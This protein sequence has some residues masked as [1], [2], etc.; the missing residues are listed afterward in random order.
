MADAPGSDPASDAD[1]GSELAESLLTV[2]ELNERIAAIVD[3][4]DGLSNVACVGE[5]IDCHETSAALYFTLTGEN[6]ELQCVLWQSR[7][8][9][10]DAALED[11]AEVIVRGNVDFWTEGGT[12]S[13]KP[14][15][16]ERV[17]DGDRR[18]RI[19]RLRAELAERG[20]F[21]DEV[22]RDL[23][24]FPA[25]VGV[26]TSRDGD[27]RHDAAETIHSRYPDVDV[28]LR[29]ANVQGDGAAESLAEGIAALDR[30]GDVDVLVVC[31][32]GGSDG[33]LLAF[34][35]EL[36]A[37]AIFECETPVVAAVGHREDRTVADEVADVSAITPTAAGETVVRRKAE[38][39]ETLAER[40]RD[41]ET[42]VDRIARTAL[43][44]RATRLE[45]AA[46]RAMRADL[47][48]LA[49]TLES[50]ADRAVGRGLERSARDLERAAANA[51]R[52]ELSALA[53]RFDLA[54]GAATTGGLAALGRR[55]E[56]AYDEL[57]R[58]REHEREKAAAVEAAA[59]TTP[60]WVR[61]VIV[62]LVALVLC[63]L[64]ALALVAL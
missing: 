40:E 38:V 9:E 3:A 35:T 11:G 19:E 44:D 51:T 39:L 52:V 20:W 26:V 54:A 61:V 30:H 27:A 45:S 48:G 49:T 14:W 53:T 50:G 13:V 64:G 29:H 17:G 16:V 60:T 63:L 22:K 10:M 28:V 4:A 12:V 25:R 47:E 5:V 21:A 23:P 46:G 59:S 32:G 6:A 8:R 18:A 56:D 15:Q 7:Y 34:Q 43:D 33:D 58:E 1:S 2:D 36:V 31:R 37:R 62:V 42:A 57:D 41:L 55:L 24:A